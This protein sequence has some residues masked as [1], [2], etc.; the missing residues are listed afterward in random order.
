M[1]PA[2]LIRLPEALV[3]LDRSEPA[4][5]TM[6]SLTCHSTG[7]V[8]IAHTTVWTNVYTQECMDPCVQSCVRECILTRIIY[9]T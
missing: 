1:F 4:K 6:D 2:S 7:Q 5:S 8:N 9:F 3:F